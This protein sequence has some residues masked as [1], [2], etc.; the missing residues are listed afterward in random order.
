METQLD[1]LPD[2]EFTFLTKDSEL[3]SG[4]MCTWSIKRLCDKLGVKSYLDAMQ[5]LNKFD[6]DDLAEFLLAP[7][8]YKFRKK[9][10]EFTYTKENA[11]DWIDDLGGEYGDNM[12]KL[13]LHSSASA[14]LKNVSVEKTET[15][16]DKKK[17]SNGTIY[18]EPTMQAE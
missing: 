4:R 9:E 2:G 17:L 16:D 18:S 11:Y 12:A 8:E 7:V 1:L 15:E 5:Q 3:I 6:T 14:G 13:I 10:S